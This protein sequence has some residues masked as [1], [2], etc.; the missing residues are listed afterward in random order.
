MM[1]ANM[2]AAEDQWSL[3]NSTM[4]LIAC[5]VFEESWCSMFCCLSAYSAG[6]WSL[7][8][9]WIT[10]FITMT[11]EL[12]QLWVH[13]LS[14][15]SC[16]WLC[17]W[18]CGNSERLAR[19]W[20]AVIHDV[21][22]NFRSLCKSNPNNLSNEKKKKLLWLLIEVSFNLKKSIYV[23]S[24]NHTHVNKFAYMRKVI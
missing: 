23:H 5:E 22:L 18:L 19:L 24:L 11:R 14:W 1:K 13:I 20:A 4:A 17:V 16:V 12:M 15:R 7:W 21:L 3:V 10:I 8:C 9:K 6:L 2:I